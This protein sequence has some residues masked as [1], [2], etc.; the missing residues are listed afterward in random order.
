MQSSS[1][2]CQNCRDRNNWGLVKRTKGILMGHMVTGLG[3]DTIQI[4]GTQPKVV[5]H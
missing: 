2:V 3:Q 1:R 4:E 5:D